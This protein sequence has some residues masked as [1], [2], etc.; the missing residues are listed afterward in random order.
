MNTLED[1]II[2]YFE[3]LFLNFSFFFSP[4]QALPQMKTR[5]GGKH[6]AQIIGMSL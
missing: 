5:T 6:G 4:L 3:A 1:T 2:V